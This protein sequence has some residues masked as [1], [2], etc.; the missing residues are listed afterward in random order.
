[1]NRIEGYLEENKQG[2]EKSPIYRRLNSFFSGDRD[3][4]E[5]HVVMKRVTILPPVTQNEA[6]G[7]F[8]Q[9]S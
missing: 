4:A 9:H 6:W 5:V 7:S 2:L 3:I 8:P 1:M